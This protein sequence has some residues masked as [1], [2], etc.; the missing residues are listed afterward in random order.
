[1]AAA[2]PVPWPGYGAAPAPSA[3][4]RPSPPVVTRV[5]D[6]MPWVTGEAPSAPM[7][8]APQYRPPATEAFPSVTM[9]FPAAT[10]TEPLGAAV[11]AA[12][13]SVAT[14]APADELDSTRVAVPPPAQRAALYAEAPVLA[15]LTWDDGTRM[16]VYG[17]TLYGR[18]PA[19]ETG[20]VSV[21]VRDETL[22]LSKTHFEIGGDAG[23]AWI[24]DR[25]STNGTVLV[26]DGVRIP[27]AP[28][29]RTTLRVGDQL[30]FGDRRV[31]VGAA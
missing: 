14:I 28:A 5:I 16:A 20:A 13:A 22:S 29:G 3:P 15:V 9:P 19:A 8:R 4:V 18:N 30:E 10:T 31:A 23:G 1:V 26:R 21:A 17:R 12:A 25:H 11:A 24:A 27:L 6:G 7:V 2:A